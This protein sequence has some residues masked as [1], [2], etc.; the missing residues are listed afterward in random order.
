MR[1]RESIKPWRTLACVLVLC[2][3][4]GASHADPAQA[5]A[6]FTERATRTNSAIADALARLGSDCLKQGLNLAGVQHL[7]QALEHEPDNE[8]AMRALGH[9]KKKVEG[10]AK[11]VLDPKKAPPEQDAQ[12]ITPAVRAEYRK[13]RDKLYA[14]TAKELVGLGQFAAKQGLEAHARAT[15]EAALRY[16]AL[17]EEALKGAGWVKESGDWV[18]PRE[19]VHR[20]AARKALDNPPDSTELETVPAWA[21][22]LGDAANPVTGSRAGN[23]TILGSGSLHAEWL[24]YAAAAR[25]LA[26]AALGG[27]APEM[28]LFVARNRKQQQAYAT[29]R[30]PGNPGLAAEAWCVEQGECAVESDEKSDKITFERIVLAVAIHEV[31]A[32]CGEPSHPWFEIG[33]ATNLTRRLCESVSQAPFSGNPA[34]PSEAGRWKRTLLMQVAEETQPRVEKL[35]VAR[36]PDESQVILAHFFTRYLVQERAGALE[37]F[38]A[39]VKAGETM[40]SALKA[41]TQA[42]LARIEQG[43]LGWLQRG[44]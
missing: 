4:A 35:L 39:A 33:Y 42:D 17:N 8:K 19:V 32:R 29:L 40:E 22:G 2:L 43:F 28:T 41:A 20:Q 23:L 44:G 16:D 3:V 21:T 24:R 10:E 25:T 37:S 12:G 14:E 9:E 18:S 6:K 1:S 38:C 11:W 36:D 30:H 7:R 13:A 27:E 26:A 5:E 15:F 34:G 31:R